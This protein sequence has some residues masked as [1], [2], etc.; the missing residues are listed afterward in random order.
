MN[1]IAFLLAGP[2]ALTH[3]GVQRLQRAALKNTMSPNALRNFINVLLRTYLESICETGKF[4]PSR[5]AVNT[6]EPY[7]ERLTWHSITFIALSKL[8]ISFVS[9][10]SISCKLSHYGL[11]TENPSN[12]PFS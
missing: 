7:G 8:Q 1:R 10:P 5:L 12:S 2:L 3:L 4:G 11:T 6:T 9:K